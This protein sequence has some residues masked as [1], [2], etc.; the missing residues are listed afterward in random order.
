M[1]HDYTLSKRYKDTKGKKGVVWFFYF[2]DENLK[3]IAKSTGTNKKY[4]AEEFAKSF[5]KKDD[6]SQITLKEYTSLFF[7]RESCPAIKR[8]HAKAKSFS[9]RMANQR[10]SH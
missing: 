9:E 10:R 8:Q 1:K 6:R 5:L 2:Y 3:R 7:V 4:E